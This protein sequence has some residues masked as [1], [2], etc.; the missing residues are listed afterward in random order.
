M[1]QLHQHYA[2][3]LHEKEELIASLHIRLRDLEQQG[4]KL[5]CQLRHD[6]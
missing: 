5:E 4:L 3:I 2:S 1:A 6:V